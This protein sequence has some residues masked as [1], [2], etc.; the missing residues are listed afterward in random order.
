M[1]HFRLSGL[2]AGTSAAV[3]VSTGLVLG[4]PAHAST[5]QPMLS[6]THG[7]RVDQHVRELG[8][9]NGDGRADVVGF[10]DPGTFVAYGQADG[11][12]TAPQ[13]KIR[14][15]GTA[16]G[17]N[18]AQH[19]RT[20]ADVDGDGRDDLVGFG[21]AG[22]LV[23]YAQP[24]GTFTPAVLKVDDF[25]YDQGWRVGQHPREV[26][27]INADFA[28]D[29]VGFG[30]SGVHVSA[31]LINREFSDT[32]K[33]SDSYG[34]NRGWRVHQHPRTVADVDGDGF[35]D[36]VGFGD[37]GVYV[38]YF[39][40]PSATFGPATLKVPN[41]GTE[42]GWRVDQHPREPA[43]ANGDGRADVVGFGH[44]GVS[45]AYAQAGQGFTP[46]SVELED[47][48]TVQGWRGDRHLRTLADVNGDG[49]Q[50]LVGFGDA[51]VH[52]A[53]GQAD[54]TFGDPFLDVGEFGS[55]G[56]WSEDRY[57]RLLG[58]VNGDGRD[59]V[60]GFGHSAT[61]VELS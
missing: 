29:I 47:F 8:D 17:W 56:G 11:T 45:V 3:L 40:T 42:Q 1:K 34:Y 43:D 59:D 9:V 20:V 31:G 15:F 4:G 27:D 50:D 24:D 46:V 26:T 48:G 30:Y 61:Y 14:N 7:W 44:R 33:R 41:F 2:F 10:G 37:A 54:N 39:D 22:V 58:D 60:V 35:A 55:N 18:T 16:Q 38:S 57:P 13:L 36:A 32:T 23:S 51:G 6:F 28:A 19:L 49:I 21:N 12:F 25:G 5:A 53:H 52:V